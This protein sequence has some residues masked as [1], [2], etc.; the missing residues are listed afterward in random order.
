MK[1]TNR[2]HTLTKVDGLDDGTRMATCTDPDLFQE[3]AL[4]LSVAVIERAVENARLMMNG[5]R[6]NYLDEQRHE[7]VAVTLESEMEFLSS[8]SVWHGWLG[9]NPL[10][11]TERLKEGKCTKPVIT[12]VR[13]PTQ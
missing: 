10:A 3:G 9:L 2:T 4:R 6:P 5:D 8:H 13:K 12:L 7:G 11:I 1:V